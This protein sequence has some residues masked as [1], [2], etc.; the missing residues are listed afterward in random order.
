MNGKVKNLKIDIK[1]HDMLKK[2]CD[3][4]GL[5]MYKFVEQLIV[6]K[7]SGKKDIYGEN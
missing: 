4:K 5:K 1:V 2:Y 3:N 7:C 6:D